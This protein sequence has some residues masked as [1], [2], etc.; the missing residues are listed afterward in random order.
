MS[1]FLLHR[2]RVKLCPF[3]GSVHVKLCLCGPVCRSTRR[4]MGSFPKRFSSTMYFPEIEPRLPILV[5]EPLTAVRSVLWPLRRVS[6]R[7]FLTPFFFFF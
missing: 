6:K 5:V 2:I 4:L 1:G 7:K 3:S